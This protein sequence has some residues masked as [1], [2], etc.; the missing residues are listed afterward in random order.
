MAVSGSGENVAQTL[1]E[2]LPDSDLDT[3]FVN[4]KIFP[5]LGN[6]DKRLIDL[7]PFSRLPL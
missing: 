3:G 2:H 5:L 6:P 1:L 7:S 4:R